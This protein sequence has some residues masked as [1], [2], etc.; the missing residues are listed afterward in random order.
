MP[1]FDVYRERRHS[2]E[3]LGEYRAPTAQSAALAAGREHTA[4]VLGVRMVGGATASLKIFRRE[5]TYTPAPDD[6]R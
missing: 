1:L 2:W 3:W 4:E 5:S 6:D